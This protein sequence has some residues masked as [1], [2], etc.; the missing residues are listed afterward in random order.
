MHVYKLDHDFKQRKTT[1]VE[2]KLLDAEGNPCKD[3]YGVELQPATIEAAQIY[4]TWSDHVI[5]KER[6]D[7][8]RAEREARLEADRIERNKRYAREEEARRERLL[9][10]QREEARKRANIIKFFTD[11]GI[12][13]DLIQ[14]DHYRVYFHRDQLERRVIE[15][16]TD[17]G[18]GA[19]PASD[20]NRI[21]V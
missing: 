12:P 4:A 9:E 1:L 7:K 19:E 18:A 14:M 8:A 15:S 21:E 6:H 5:E 16:N 3:H 11:A 2:G 20:T 10:V 17:S 13:E